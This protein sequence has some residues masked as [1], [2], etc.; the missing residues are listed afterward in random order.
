[1]EIILKKDLRLDIIV[2]VQGMFKNPYKWG[3]LFFVI[4]VQKIKLQRK[5]FF[6]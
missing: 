6:G 2:I 3:K 5:C 1:M 4:L